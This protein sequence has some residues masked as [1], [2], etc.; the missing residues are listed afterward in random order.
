MPLL[1]NHVFIELP[2]VLPIELPIALPIVL[3]ITLP[4]VLP[5]VLPKYK[6]SSTLNQA[7]HPSRAG[8]GPGCR[9]SLGG[10]HLKLQKPAALAS[11]PRKE[12]KQIQ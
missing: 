8:P 11:Q 5:M 10:S 12:V 4:I 1:R 7:K 3:P 2:I 6:P 9:R